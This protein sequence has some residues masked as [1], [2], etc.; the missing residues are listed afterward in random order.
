VALRTIS[1]E[2]DADASREAWT[3]LYDGR[4]ATRKALIRAEPCEV[5]VTQAG[6]RITWTIHPVLIL[7]LA[8]R[9]EGELPACADDLK[10]QPLGAW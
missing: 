8:H 6:T 7:P 1:P 10:P 2:L 4:M 9:Q 3:W 5:S